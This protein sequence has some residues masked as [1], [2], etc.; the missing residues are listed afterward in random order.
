MKMLRFQSIQQAFPY[1]QK[2]MILTRP[3]KTKTLSRQQAAAWPTRGGGADPPRMMGVTHFMLSVCRM[4]TSSTSSPALC[5]LHTLLKLHLACVLVLLLQM[6]MPC[7]QA[8]LWEVLSGAGSL[9]CKQGIADCFYVISVSDCIGKM[10]T[11]KSKT[12]LSTL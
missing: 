1:D 8:A 11:T 2:P 7:S 10:S 3:P 6:R 12:A 9:S 5:P 4:V